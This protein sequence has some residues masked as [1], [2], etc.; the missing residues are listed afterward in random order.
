MGDKIRN[1][2]SWK[3]WE[4]IGGRLTK[5]RKDRDRKNERMRLITRSERQ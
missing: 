5:D 1:V 3:G 4:I 2:T